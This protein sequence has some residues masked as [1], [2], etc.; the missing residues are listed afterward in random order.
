VALPTRSLL[1]A[2]PAWLAL[3]LLLVAGLR[4]AW[5]AR[6]GGWRPRRPPEPVWSPYGATIV[7]GVA[8]V[9][10]HYLAGPWAYTDALKDLAMGR[11]DSVAV[12][13]L[14]LASLL[15]GAVFGAWQS[16]RLVWRRPA[17]AVMVR[18]FA[19]GLVMAIGSLMVPGGNDALLL[20]G[21]PNLHGYALLAL[22]TMALTIAGV[23]LLVQRR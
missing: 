8:I 20:I 1:V 10:L 2:A 13:A 23:Q 5:L 6:A 3:P 4:L 9:F 19:G 15:G 21:A 11:S 16:G 12:Q 22:A 18:V 7:I 14:L 17:V